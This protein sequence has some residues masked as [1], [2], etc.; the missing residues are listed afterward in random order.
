MFVRNELIMNQSKYK[1][2]LIKAVKA[3]GANVKKFREDFETNGP[4]VP[5]IEPREALNRLKLQIEEYQIR[6]RK[7]KSLN[8]G[9]TLF[10]LP[11][12]TYPELELTKSQLELLEKLYNLYVKV[13]DSTTRWKEILWT[14]MRGEVES[15]IEQIGIFSGDVQKLPLKLRQWNAFR[16][17]KEEIDELKEVLPLAQGLA[18]PSIETRHWEEIRQIT[19]A[20]E[21]KFT[22]RGDIVDEFCFKDLLKIPLLKH[23]EEIEDITDSADK[24]EKI[25]TDYKAIVLYWQMLE[26]EIITYKGIECSILGGTIIEIQEKLENDIMAL[27]QMNA[28]RYVKPFKNAV[29]NQITN[30]SEAA[31]TIEKWLKV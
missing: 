15:L 8:A 11:N 28:Q 25:W 20:K 4:M 31:D 22:E 12:A 6:E 10:G 26:I 3:L 21:P 29:V 14:D 16:E 5:G 23:K 30:L 24:Q 1:K 19:G 9:E 18:K 2:S 17:L 13:K 7:Y 27:N